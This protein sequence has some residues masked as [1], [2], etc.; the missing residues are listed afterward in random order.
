[1]MDKFDHF[2][3]LSRSYGT[4][5]K[6]INDTAVTNRNRNASNKYYNMTNKRLT[7]NTTFVV[8]DTT[9]IQ[10][11]SNTEEM[12]YQ[13]PKQVELLIDTLFKKKFNFVNWKC[14]CVNRKNMDFNGIFNKSNINSNNAKNNSASKLIFSLIIQF[15]IQIARGE[16]QSLQVMYN[17]ENDQSMY[18][19]CNTA[20]KL[21]NKISFGCYD[22][23]I[24]EWKGA[25]R[26]VSSMGKQSTGKS[27]LLNHLFGTKFDISGMR[28]TDGSW[29]SLRIID[30]IMYITL[31]FEGLGSTERTLT[32]DTLLSV[33]NCAVS[34]CTLFKV[35]N[36]FDQDIISM[37]KR[38]EQ[39]V[40]LINNG[41]I[42][43]LKVNCS[44]EQNKTEREPPI[45]SKIKL[46]QGIL[47][48]C[49]K[50]I[51]VTEYRA[52]VKEFGD[53]IKDIIL[54]DEDGSFAKKMYQLKPNV[55]V[56]PVKY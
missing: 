27:Y 16:K 42:D 41:Y 24:N 47:Y 56:E 9:N 35:A 37:F 22:A 48:I 51:Q 7:L 49:V 39:G 34:N 29:L 23:V 33:F 4:N 40:E 3:I 19:E 32:E 38:F 8:I 28:C 12:I 45:P 21:C 31:D 55:K 52:V 15:P 43:S 46:F 50:D 54:G 14:C 6:S 36:N 18:K 5:S 11:N 25:I 2:P 10:I 17:G 26:V 1:M 30:N 20:T 44:S 53:K 13:I